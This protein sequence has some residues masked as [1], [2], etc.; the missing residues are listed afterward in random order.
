M[1][2]DTKNKIIDRYSSVDLVDI[3]GIDIEE[4][5]DYLEPYVEEHIELIVEDL[6]GY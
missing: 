3:L 5:L 1:D 2:T 4:L 6:D